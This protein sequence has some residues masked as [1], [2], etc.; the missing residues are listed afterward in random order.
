MRKGLIVVLTAVLVVAFAVPAMADLK[1]SGF[2]RTKAMLSNFFDGRSKPS[3]RTDAEEQTNSYNE[4]R[5][6]IK[7]EIG[8]ADVKAVFQFESDMNWG[9]ASGEA[10][11]N[12]GGALSADSVQLETKNVYVWFKIPDTSITASVGQQPFND[13]YAGVFSNAADFTSIQVKG[14][15][16]PVKWT[17]AW[18]KLYETT[19]S[20]T[21]ADGYNK[22]DD[23]DIYVAAV[24]F[25]PAK[26][27]SLGLNFYALQDRQGNGGGENAWGPWAADYNKVIGDDTLSGYDV[28]VYM[29][30]VNFAMNAGAVK[31]SA[32]AFYQFGKAESVNPANDFDINGYM[33][34]IRAD[35]KVG[36]GKAFVE[37]FY[38]SGGDDAKDYESPT[39]LGDYQR[40]GFGT[41]GNSGFGRTNMYFLFG[42]DSLNVSQCLIGCSGGEAGDSFG[43]G[44]RGLMHLAAGYSQ[45]F[46]DKLQGAVN[47]GTLYAVKLN[48]TLDKDLTYIRNE[49]DKDMGTEINVKVD[50]EIQKKL[51][52]SLVGGYMLLGDFFQTAPGDDEFND[53]Y[54]M[55]Y[56]KLAYS[57]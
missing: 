32:F 25:T 56:A 29:P 21:G 3:L 49:R 1:V 16:E 8:T 5:A 24:E 40:S 17:L 28:T 42:A 54:Y 55:G 19:P 13:H 38:I 9:V 53:A 23:V 15:L 18:G 41:G 43:N 35:V 7:F 34:D 33:L 14:T 36:P 11:R 10:N 22:A 45:K 4:Q 31:L 50:Y 39:F 20:S 51:T 52:F 26:D 12:S 47:I 2:Y 30:G 6:R 48:N 57:F 44:G 46:T 37:G 27:M